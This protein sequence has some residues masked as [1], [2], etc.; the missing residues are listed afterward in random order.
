MTSTQARRVI[1]ES[2]D[3]LLTI[4]NKPKLSLKELDDGAVVERKLGC[5]FLSLGLKEAKRQRRQGL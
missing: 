2:I 4:R 3:W 1:N 5:A